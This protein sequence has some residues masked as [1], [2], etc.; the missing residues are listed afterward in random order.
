M[1]VLLFGVKKTVLNFRMKEQQ[2]EQA[3]INQDNSIIPFSITVQKHGLLD[4][5]DI[6]ANKIIEIAEL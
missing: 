5:F 1:I 4:K 3:L 6:F 2:E